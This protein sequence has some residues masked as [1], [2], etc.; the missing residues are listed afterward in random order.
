MQFPHL[1]SKLHP[2]GKQA[3]KVG[4]ICHVNLNTITEVLHVNGTSGEVFDWR[5]GDS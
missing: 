5:E 2:R 3:G 1:S 4:S